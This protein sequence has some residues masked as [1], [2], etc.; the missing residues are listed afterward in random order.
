MKIFLQNTG[1]SDSPV[2]LN[3]MAQ[4]YEHE[5]LPFNPALALNAL[6]N[7]MQNENWGRIWLIRA[8]STLV[9]YIALTFGFSLECFGQDAFV[10]EFFILEPFRKKGIGQKI[11]QMVEIEC[12]LNG[13]H[14]LH[15][16]VR[17]NNSLAFQFYEKL[18]FVGK[19]YRWMSKPIKSVEPKN[20]K[21]S[22]TTVV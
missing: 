18:G 9:G 10:D 19:P 4:Y 14:A 5:Q 11:L 6:K 21:N 2:L 7:L 8:D 12:R 17:N 22:V 16:V 15:L 20:N 3:L 1:E 13:I